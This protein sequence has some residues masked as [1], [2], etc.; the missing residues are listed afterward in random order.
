MDR[1]ATVL[2]LFSV[3][4]VSAVAQSDRS[5]R[6]RVVPIPTSPPIVQPEAS[7][8]QNKTKRAPVLINSNST[9]QVIPPSK[10][11]EASSDENEVIKIDTNLVTIPV[12][13]LDRDG[14]FINGLRQQ[15][16]QIFENGV[17]QKIEFFQPVEQPFNVILMLDVSPST[18]YRINDIR[19]AAMRFLAQLRPHDRVM[20]ITFDETIRVWNAPTND[21]QILG[22]AINRAVFGQGTSVYDAI[23]FVVSEAL[24]RIEGRKAVVVFTDAV[25]TTSI[26]ADYQSTFRKVEEAD[27]LFYSVRYDTLRDQYTGYTPGGNS[28]AIQGI[29][30]NGQ[31][32]PINRG[33]ST[34]ATEAEYQTGRKYLEDLAR[35]T[36]GRKFEAEN[37]LE[38]A[39]SGI[40][41][42]L[43]RQYSIGYYPEAG[44]QQGERRQI[45][46]QVTK[47]KMVVRSRSSYVIGANN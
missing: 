24:P 3:A 19:Y 12:S 11:E 46:V 15:D 37:N 20:V 31:L 36:G 16:F 13:V 21:R 25:D 27:A 34:G 29:I 28:S 4:V 33:W 14:R 5:A 18:R 22:Y 44:G 38:A 17:Q 43:R 26:G 35:I 6:P 42:E 9:E 10:T 45:R 39:F 41:E 23:D 32:V 1:I 2:L 40:A 7:P 47:P 8:V 30:L